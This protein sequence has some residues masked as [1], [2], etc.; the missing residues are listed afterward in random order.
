VISTHTDKRKKAKRNRNLK[1]QIF[2]MNVEYNKGGINGFCVHKNLIDVV[3]MDCCNLYPAWVHTIQ[4]AI[5]QMVETDHNLWSVLKAIGKCKSGQ[6]FEMLLKALPSNHNHSQEIDGR[7]GPVLVIPQCVRTEL[8]R[9]SE[10]GKKCGHH[11]IN[12]ILQH[13]VDPEDRYTLGLLPIDSKPNRSRSRSRIVGTRGR[14]T[15]TTTTTSS[16][17]TTRSSSSRKGK[18]RND[19]KKHHQSVPPIGLFISLS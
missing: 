1:K 11:L 3:R 17:R 18:C 9:Q 14:T 12:K 15:T 5:D 7:L 8:G 4:D 16:G 2:R 13:I 6:V 19:E 10:L